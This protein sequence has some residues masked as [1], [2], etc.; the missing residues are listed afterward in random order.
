MPL[1]MTGYGYSQYENE[2]IWLKVEIKSVNS[3]YL[4]LNLRLPKIISFTEDKVRTLIRSKVER[5]KLD[6]FVT[7]GNTNGNFV[8]LELDKSMADSYHNILEEIRKEYKLKSSIYASQVAS[9]PGVVNQVE[10]DVDNDKILQAV[11]IAFE[12]ALDALTE[13]R[14]VEGKELYKDCISKIEEFKEH[15]DKIKELSLDLPK[16]YKEKLEKRLTELLSDSKVDETRLAQEV[17]FFA[18]RACVDEEIT[19]LTS[20]ISQFVDNMEQSHSGKKIDFLIQEMLRETNTIASKANNLEIT[21][22]TLE[23][24]YVLEKIREQIQNLE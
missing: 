14:R 19:R 17:A 23:M 9:Y 11:L 1:S 15:L 7:V 18:D 22:N 21:K 13:S 2:L 16:L 20:H 6:C 10:K 8:N 3:R 12:Q 5:G 4:D 24:K